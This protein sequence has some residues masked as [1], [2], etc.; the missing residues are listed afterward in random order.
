M[1]IKLNTDKQLTEKIDEF[2]SLGGCIQFKIFDIENIDNSYQT[3][4]EIA[5]RTLIEISNDW[6]VYIQKVSKELHTD[7]EQYYKQENYFD[8]LENSGIQIS[9]RDFLG[10]QFDLS[11]NKPLIKGVK[12]L[13]NE[14]FYFD[15]EEDEMNS[16]NFSERLKQFEFKETDGASG[17]FCGAFLE[18]PHS[19]RIGKNIFEHGKYFLDFCDLLFSD[20]T[21]IEIYKWSVDSSNFFEAGKEWWGA[22]FWTIYNSTKNIYIGAIAST[23][24]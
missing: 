7:R 12:R 3:H 2:D 23:T 24:D 19:V 5:K 1:T 14:Y 18:P 20:L 9:N 21:K 16:I 6:E 4:L 15:T 13:Y 17:A 10:P 22:H 11:V 8:E